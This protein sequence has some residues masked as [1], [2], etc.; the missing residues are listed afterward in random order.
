MQCVYSTT[1]S[2]PTKYVKLINAVVHGAAFLAILKK[3]KIQLYKLSWI[4][5][6]QTQEKKAT[7]TPY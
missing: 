6:I 5:T 3:P 1:L 7:T 4:S 2:V